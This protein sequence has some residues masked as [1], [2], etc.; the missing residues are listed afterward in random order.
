[1]LN[2]DFDGESMVTR[3]QHQDLP[4]LPLGLSKSS[5]RAER[6]GAACPHQLGWGLALS[7]RAGPGPVND[8]GERRGAVRP[9]PGLFYEWSGGHAP[10]PHRAP[11]LA[12]A[13]RA[14]ARAARSGRSRPWSWS[15]SRSRWSGK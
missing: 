9:P 11:G 2:V 8:F 5:L 15:R 10:E 12:A 6:H 14:A 13:S 7:A 4:E 3:S 1:M